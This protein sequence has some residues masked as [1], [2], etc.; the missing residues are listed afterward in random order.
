MSNHCFVIRTTHIEH[1]SLDLGTS[2][3]LLPFSMY[4]QLGLREL[5][6]TNV[7]LQLAD[8]STRVPRG[9]V[10]NVLVR[11]DKFYFPVD[12]IILDTNPVVNRST[13]IPVIPGRPFLAMSDAF[14]QCRNGVMRLAFGNVTCGLNIFNVEKQVGDEGEVHEVSCID[15]LVQY[16]M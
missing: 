15:S 10:E 13:Q 11:V 9:M 12:F 6:S 3:N 7:T 8:R 16:F 1:A 2:V 14:I 4:Q 5:K